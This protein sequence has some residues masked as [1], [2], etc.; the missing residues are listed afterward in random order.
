MAHS[1]DADDPDEI[2]EVQSDSSEIQPT[3]GAKAISQKGSANIATKA[4]DIT[5]YSWVI[6]AVLAMTRVAFQCQRS[7]FSYSYGY[8]GIGYQFQN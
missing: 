2:S 6:L 7:A 3:D 5:V 8:S 4:K 1:T